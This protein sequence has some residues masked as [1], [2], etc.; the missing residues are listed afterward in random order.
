MSTTIEIKEELFSTCKNCVVKEWCRL[1][2]GEFKLPFDNM[3]TYCIG[4]EKLSKAIELAKIP[5]E[6]HSANLYNYVVDDDNVDFAPILKQLLTNPVGFVTS[7]TNL[8]LINCNKGT[9]KS[10][11]ANAVLN[12]FIY[13]VCRD[14]GWFDY[15]SPVAMYVKFGAWANR[16][17][18]IYIRN[19][20]Q[21]SFEVHKELSQ[22]KDVPLLLLDDI[23]S[24]RITPIIRDLTY[25]VIDFRKEEQKS[26]IF[27][28][29]FTNSILRQDDILGD[30]VV[31][32]MFYNT[33]VIP[34]G[35]RDRREDNTYIY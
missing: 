31:S 20:A 32:R 27:T 11:T 9:G 29:N 18:D 5:K 8:A 2:S 16:Q 12:E 24:G 33:M 22:M 26:T 3:L 25:D 21:F 30:M 23:G 1:R 15:E 14:S 10:W 34:L 7:G 28:S 4:Y 19:D 6:Y 17:R 35:G 13:K